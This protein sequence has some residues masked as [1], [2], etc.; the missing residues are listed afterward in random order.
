M[1]SIG[2]KAVE[3]EAVSRCRQQFEGLLRYAG[4]TARGDSLDAAERGLFASLMQMGRSL[5]EARLEAE[6][7]GHVGATLK[8]PDGKERVCQGC[9]T[10]DYR[11]V[12]GE[13]EIRRAYYWSQGQGGIYPLDAR[14]NLPA[15][16]DSYLLVEWALK[17]G[18]EQSYDE[19]QSGLHDLLGLSVPKGVIEA[20]A[21]QV[22]ATVKG[23]YDEKAP[24]PGNPEGPVLVATADGKGV[25]MKKAVPCEAP[26][27][28]SK[29]QKLQKK[30]MAMVG[31]V[32]TSERRKE[33]EGPQALN[34]E[35]LA[36][37]K[38]RE[39]FA[40]ALHERARRR[41][42][43]VKRKAF[44]ADGQE[45]IWEMQREHFSDY[46]GILDWMHA[47]EYLWKTAYLWLP[48][49]SPKAHA[50]VEQQKTRFIRGKVKQVIR[51]IRQ[52]V[53]NGTIRGKA[54]CHTALKV[55]DYYERHRHR[56]RYDR[57]RRMGLPI[58]SG[59][60]E[61]TCRYL[62]KDRMERS[63]MRWT[64]DGAQAVLNLRA[65]VKSGHQTQFWDW[66]RKHEHQRLYQAAA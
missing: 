4:E 54:R 62:V 17:M 45:S 55:A 22:G 23:F 16:K 24:K 31:A 15:R 26:K 66:H 25:P 7:D 5:L 61:G 50:W 21:A 27:R 32:Y 9:R 6:G 14:L 1:D 33:K 56:M 44:L 42:K 41:E 58:G 57:Y 39:S 59:A 65:V 60:V 13:V 63:G 48:E 30:R 35:V 38:D 34:K 52:L 3:G 19:V 12:F 11:S 10:V 20:Q 18:V 53:R 49:S 28:L 43:G 37:L 47:A 64:I 40:E 51:T 29:G 36:E 8:G 2:R 46:V